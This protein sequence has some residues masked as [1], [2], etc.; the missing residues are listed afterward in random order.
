MRCIDCKRVVRYPSTSSKKIQMC[1]KC[2]KQEEESESGSISVVSVK[3]RKRGVN[4][5]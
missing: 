2:R 3:I 5:D 4:H 1:G